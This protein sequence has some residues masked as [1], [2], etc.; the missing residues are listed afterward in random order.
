MLYN[1]GELKLKFKSFDRREKFSVGKHFSCTL[2]S[3]CNRISQFQ[4]AFRKNW[5][6][7]D[8]KREAVGA[9]RNCSLAEKCNSFLPRR[10][11]SSVMKQTRVSKTRFSCIEEFLLGGAESELQEKVIWISRSYACIPIDVRNLLRNFNRKHGSRDTIHIPR[12]HRSR[13]LYINDLQRAENRRRR[14]SSSSL[15]TSPYFRP[16]SLISFRMLRPGRSFQHTLSRTTLG[17]VHA[18]GRNGP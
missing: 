13:K 11:S 7:G 8:G 6:L 10:S 12:K 18:S 16:A 9:R 4:F 2:I 15:W 17:A 1:T 14:T 3:K 5:K